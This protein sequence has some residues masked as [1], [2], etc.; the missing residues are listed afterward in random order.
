MQDHLTFIS[1]TL[2]TESETHFL[3]AATQSSKALTPQGAIPGHNFL[4]KTYDVMTGSDT[5][6]P[7]SFVADLINRR[8]LKWEDIFVSGEKYQAPEILSEA[9]GL[10]HGQLRIIES[11][12]TEN[13]ATQLN[14]N[15]EASAS[16]GLFEASLHSCFNT[17]E[18]RYSN[19]KFGSATDVY[20][21]YSMSLIEPKQL[22]ASMT[23]S[24]LEL[25]DHADPADIISELG[26]HYIAG[27]IVGGR[28]QSSFT[29]D[30]SSYKSDMSVSATIKAS[31]NYGIGKA[32]GSVK[33]AFEKAKASWEQATRREVM[34]VGGDEKLARSFMNGKYDEWLESLKKTPAAVG[35][36]GKGLVGIWHLAKDKQ[37]SQAIKKAAIE[38]MKGYQPLGR[39]PKLP[40]Q[41]GDVLAFKAANG[42]Y[43]SRNNTPDIR[44]RA[45]G[46][47]KSHSVFTV[48]SVN[49]NKFTLLGSNDK[50]LS[51]YYTKDMWLY[52]SNISR[53]SWW[54]LLEA[55]ENRYRIKNTDYNK[56]WHLPEA[57]S[58]ISLTSDHTQRNSEF[59]VMIIGPKLT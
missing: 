47:A 50:F 25:L 46:T 36:P 33:T 12:S 23:E 28:A 5:P 59:D 14:V 21:T 30:T 49:H 2:F 7:D 54:E 4:G 43:I 32:T 38:H 27:L 45:I 15:V 18:S 29:I 1:S 22:R 17:S 34:L 41:V 37:K 10:H 56:C 11:D 52:S 51:V 44:L 8:S 31:Y 48:Q 42:R 3:N 9:G 35:F 39:T 6:H 53:Y 24:A 13:Y 57:N 58:E 20:Q 19:R 26:T 16:Y 40:L 55:S